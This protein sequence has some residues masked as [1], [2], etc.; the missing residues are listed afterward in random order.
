M[1]ERVGTLNVRGDLSDEV[2][3]EALAVMLD[4]CDLLGLQEW[5]PNR[6]K[7]AR[8]FDGWGYTKPAAGCPPL[9][10]REARYV[11]LGGEPVVL[12]EGR[13]VGF[14]PGRRSKLPDVV[15]GLYRL[16]DVEDDVIIP[17]LNWHLPATVEARGAYRRIKNVLSPRARMHREAR[18]AGRRLMEQQAPK[19]DRA[20]IVGDTNFHD[21][22][23]RSFGSCW[24]GR[25][26]KGTHGN[27]TIDIVYGLA[28]A[29]DVKTLPVGSDH[30]GVVATYRTGRGGVP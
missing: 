3:R 4:H 17:I 29:K 27:R 9:M 15:S 26:L 11:V 13:F 2:A 24:T 18:R 5:G 1:T 14:I 8:E 23:L 6:S 20:Y 12:A 28:P 10:F 25:E 21:M 22:Q 16:Q 19:P 30:K 7:I